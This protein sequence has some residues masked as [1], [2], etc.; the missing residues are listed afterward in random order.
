MIQVVIVV[1]VV[2]VAVLAL[3]LVGV[4]PIGTSGTQPAVV[5]ES[6]ADALTAANAFVGGVAGGPW[7]LTELGG[8]DFTTSYS[9]NSELTPP[10]GCSAT[11]DSGITIP[12]YTGNY[13][14]G[15][16]ATWALV[17]VNAPRTS[18]LTLVVQ[19]GQA[20]EEGLISGTDCSVGNM[21]AL[22]STFINSTVAAAVA[23]TSPAIVGFVR[24]HSSANAEFLLLS[25]AVLDSPSG[26]N[27]AVVYSTCDFANPSAGPVQGSDAY[28][29][30]N[31]TSGAFEGGIS[32]PSENCTIGP[33]NTSTPIASAFAA[34]NPV[35]SVCSAG[36]TFMAN[37]CNAGDYTYTL[38]V[39]A[40][41][42]TFGSVLFE[43]KTDTGSFFTLNGPGGFSVLNITGGLEAAFSVG[44]SGPLAMTSGFTDFGSG[45]STSTALTSLD[46]ILIDMGTTSPVGM[47][48]SF[49]VA[50]TG[51]YTGTTEPVALP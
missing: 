14:N 4:I 5:P 10:S 8:I 46:T 42:V 34:A 47:G 17:Y 32:E 43:V 20:R 27:W 35:F 33:Q 18:E 26:L 6:S 36:S 19:N 22:P 16:L 12:A 2:A 11:S 28:G 29:V 50:G 44:S 21:T 40:S 3:V 13:S 31:A 38:A 9:N 49:V 39:E 23:L 41:T 25:G 7:Y 48:L 15:K 30:V 24:N 51:S 45:L 1:A 37:G